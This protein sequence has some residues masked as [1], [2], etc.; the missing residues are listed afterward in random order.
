MPDYWQVK[1]DGAV[2]AHGPKETAPDKDFRAKLR[3]A[4]CKIYIDGKLCKA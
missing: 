4:G 1:R 3:K 2:L